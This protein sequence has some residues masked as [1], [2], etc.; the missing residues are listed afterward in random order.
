MSASAARWVAASEHTRLVEPAPANRLIFRDIYGAFYDD[1]RRWIGAL[2]G[3][4]FDCEDL[5]QDVFLVVYR[6]LSDFDGQNVPGW[7][8]QITRRRVRDYRQLSWFR[9]VLGGSTIE[10]ATAALGD[11]PDAVLSN[12]EKREELT[13]LLSRVPAPQRDAFVLFQIAGYSGE[14]IAHMQGVPLNTVWT[15]IH[16][17]RARLAAGALRLR[18]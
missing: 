13:R 6:R 12:K 1:V 14:E 8:Y 16:K 3:S 5:V 15:R 17:T 11:A 9:L 2:G 4:E 18:H 7:L 10:K